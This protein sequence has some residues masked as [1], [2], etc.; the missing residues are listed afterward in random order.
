MRRFLRDNGLSLF[1]LALF[2][3]TVVGQSFAGWFDFNSEQRMH[4]SEAYSY[5]RYAASSHFGGAVLENWQSEW[6]QFLVFTMATI[7]LLQRGSPESKPLEDAGVGS[8]QKQRIG[9]YAPPQSPRL[10]RYGDWRTHLYANSFVIVMATIFIGTWAGQSVTNWTQYN[11]ELIEH[12]QTSVPWSSYIVSS[13]FWEKTLQN[14]QSEFLAVG[15]MVIF[16]VFLRQR[17]SPESKPVGAPH[18]E[19]GTSG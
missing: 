15:V 14:W 3:A 12:H 10:A 16:T 1:F 8:R 17:G 7:W 18:D 13:D 4:G 2:L 9:G 6:L 19:T 5:W 11:E